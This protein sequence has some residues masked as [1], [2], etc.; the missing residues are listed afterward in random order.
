MQEAGL[1]RHE[2][3]VWR[4]GYKGAGLEREGRG[5]ME[6]RGLNTGKE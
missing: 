3:W 1:H 2:F 4:R 6:G 5:Y